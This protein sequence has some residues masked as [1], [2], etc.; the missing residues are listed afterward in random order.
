MIEHNGVDQLAFAGA[1]A[2]NQTIG[3]ITVVNSN[4]SVMHVRAV[5]GHYGGFG[6]GAARQCI[7]ANGAG[8]EQIF[9]DSQVTATG[10]EWSF[11]RTASTTF[12]ITKAAGNYSGSGYWFV[13]ITGNNL[14]S[15]S[16]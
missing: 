16:I 5:F 11:T 8:S 3:P 7:M 10:G 1:S 6:Y 4:Q 14:I 12:T 15:A 2:G 13:T 9:V